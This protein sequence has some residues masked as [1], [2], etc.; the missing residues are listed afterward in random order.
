MANNIIIFT[1][2]AVPNNQS[3]MKNKGGVGV[4]FGDNDPRNI[5][6]IIDT[7]TFDKVT[8]QVCETLACIKAIETIANL[9]NKSN[10][11]IKTDS[12]Y[13]VNSMTTWANKWEKNNWVKADGKPVQNLELIKKLYQLS[14][15]NNVK[16]IHVKAHT[17]AP[18]IDSILYSDYYGNYMADK[19]AT[20]ACNTSAA[21]S[22]GIL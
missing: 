4:F 2:G 13:L 12:M 7:K 18:P 17:K 10:I 1:D 15:N 8:N 6:L 21:G 16:Y 22:P 5:S 9:S 20:S 3:K 14:K 19:L 11:I